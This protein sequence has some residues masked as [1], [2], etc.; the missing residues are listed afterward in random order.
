MQ[1]YID[2]E[3]NLNAGSN[4]DATCQDYRQT[5][6]YNCRAGTLCSHANFMKTTCSGTIFDCNAIDANGIACLV[7]KKI[8]I[9]YIHSK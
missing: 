8:K 7:V 9:L 3:A 1:G 6:N 2:N 5:Q 4:C